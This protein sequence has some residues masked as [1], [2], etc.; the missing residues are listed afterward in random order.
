MTTSMP[1]KCTGGRPWTDEEDHF[2][3]TYGPADG[4][5]VVAERDLARSK[6]AGRSRI[7]VLREM[8]PDLVARYPAAIPG[9]ILRSG[10]RSRPLQV[11][12][13]S[14]YIPEPNS[15]C[16]LWDSATSPRGYG[17]LHFQ[18]KTLKATRV[19]YTL[20]KGPIADG[21]YICH[22][23]DNPYCVNPDHLLVVSQ[24]EIPPLSSFQGTQ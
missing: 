21:L 2:L 6:T 15:G 10:R 7:Q 1:W 9:A 12:F 13:D 3:L 22:H 5:D 11:I 17:Y 20:H 16:W 23:C 4:F 14:H 18:G 8:H 24:F 19:S